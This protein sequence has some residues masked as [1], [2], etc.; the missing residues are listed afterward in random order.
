MSHKTHFFISEGAGGKTSRN[1]SA[2]EVIREFF[3]QHPKP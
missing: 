2:T 1:F 3:S